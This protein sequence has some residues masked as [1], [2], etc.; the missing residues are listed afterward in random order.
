MDNRP[1]LHLFSG[2]TSLALYLLL[3]MV[4]FSTLITP[5]FSTDQ[6][7]SMPIEINLNRHTLGLVCTEFRRDQR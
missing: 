3:L 7:Q 5:K 4:V 6:T 2:L 1:A